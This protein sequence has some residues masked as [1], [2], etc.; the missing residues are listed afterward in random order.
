MQLLVEF[1]Q[2]RYASQYRLRQ[3]GRENFTRF[4]IYYLSLFKI[5][6]LVASKIEKNLGDFFWEGYC[7]SKGGH[8]I[9][10]N[11]VTESKQKGGLGIL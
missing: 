1:L 9:N 2:K 10:W 8:L 5:P 3:I 6:F 4:P 11:K 7:E